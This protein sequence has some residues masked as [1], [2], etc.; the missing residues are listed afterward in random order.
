MAP[1]CTPSIMLLHGFTA[2]PHECAPDTLYRLVW[3]FLHTF[4]FYLNPKIVCFSMTHA[5]PKSF[6]PIR[7][8]WP[9]LI[10]VPGIH[11]YNQSKSKQHL[12]WFIYLCTAYDQHRERHTETPHIMTFRP[13]DK[14]RNSP[15]LARHVGD[16]IIIFLLLCANFY[17]Q[18]LTWRKRMNSIC[19]DALSFHNFFQ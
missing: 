11:K 9:H 10:M 14:L 5:L 15:Y 8:F 1:L 16:I 13:I 19:S 7:G 17:S 4:P 6:S 3:P 2:G 18:F 12:D